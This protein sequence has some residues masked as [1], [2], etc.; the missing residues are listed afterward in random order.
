MTLKL[1]AFEIQSGS[2]ELSK[3][4][5]LSETFAYWKLGVATA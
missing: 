3:Y 1:L 5:R 4:L 2:D